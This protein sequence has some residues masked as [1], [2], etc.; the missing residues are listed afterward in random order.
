MTPQIILLAGALV[1]TPAADPAP[2]L[3]ECGDRIGPLIFSPLF[4]SF[5]LDEDGIFFSLNMEVLNALPPAEAD[6]IVQC[7]AKLSAPMPDDDPAV[8]NPVVPEPVPDQEI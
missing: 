7:L 2:S 1:A 6:A 4:D 5:V 3:D 8:D